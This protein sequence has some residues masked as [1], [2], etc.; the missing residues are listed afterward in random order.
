MRRRAA[1]LAF[2]LLVLV[3]LGADLI[4][5]DLPLAVRVDGR[6]HLL[7]CLTH[8]A[9]LADEDQQTLSRRATFL[10]PTPIPYGPLASHPGGVTTPLQPP[11]RTHYWGTDDRG[12]DVAARLVH[13]ARTALI[14]GGAAVGLFLLIGIA[15]GLACAAA[16]AIDLILGRVIEIGLIFPAYFLLLCVQ[17]ALSLR[18]PP[19]LVTVAAAIALTRWPEV[20]RLTRAEALRQM[21]SPH[22]EAARALGVAPAA[23]AWRHVLPFALGPSLV[24]AAFGFGQAVLI[25]AGLSFLGLGV[26]PPTPT[27]GELL[28]E[29]HSAGLPWWLV[30]GPAGAIAGVVYLTGRVAEEVR[31]GLAPGR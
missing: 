11:S 10:L 26:A 21:A 6:L 1:P 7:P 4:A 13:G 24:T 25:E 16:P 17:G 8:P 20:A 30:L 15:C 23:I 2:A 31:R 29:A 12:R 14:V 18:G 22:V 5:S 3:A 9:A 27:W 19:S 28:A